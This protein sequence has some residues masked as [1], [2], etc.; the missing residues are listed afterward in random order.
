VTGIRRFFFPLLVIVA[1]A[2]LAAE[3]LRD[4][5]SDNVVIYSDLIRQAERNPAGIDLVVFFPRSKK[6]E[7]HL[8]TRRTFT[9]HYP[10]DESQLALQQLLESKHIRFDSKGAGQSALWT[11]L[12][13]LLP[14]VLLFGFWLFLM[15]RTRSGRDK[16]DDGR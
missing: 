11:L 13:T 6:I 12:S 10:S 7:V 4:D 8:K 2:W 15:E 5:S 9:T 16:E 3:T 14:F 1:L